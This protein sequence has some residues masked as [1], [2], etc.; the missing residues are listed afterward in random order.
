MRRD[1]SHKYFVHEKIRP[2]LLEHGDLPPNVTDDPDGADFVLAFAPY[3]PN[4]I[5]NSPFI[6]KRWFGTREVNLRYYSIWQQDVWGMER[7]KP[8]PI[9]ILPKDARRYGLL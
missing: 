6:I 3:L 5:E 7:D 2:K 8:N 4:D 9:L 1:S